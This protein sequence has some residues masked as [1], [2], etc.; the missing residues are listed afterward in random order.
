MIPLSGARL[1][2]RRRVPCSHTA[3]AQK[4]TTLCMKNPY[5][6]PV[7][8]TCSI[9]AVRSLG[10]SSASGLKQTRAKSG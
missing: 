1:S 10:R 8:D 2:E 7:G 5:A 3:I 6:L 4:S 9:H